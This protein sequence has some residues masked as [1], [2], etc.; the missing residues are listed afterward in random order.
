MTRRV[1]VVST[2]PVEERALRD[3]I[4]GDPA[5]IKVV[6][7]AAKLSRL[8]WLA[9]DD[10]E[11]IRKAAEAAERTASALPGKTDAEVGDSD[12][13]QAIEDALREWPADEVFVVTPPEEQATSLEEDA[14]KE[15]RA[16][17]GVPVTHLTLGHG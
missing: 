10:D 9:N 4:G 14:R 3:R 12:P 1:L 16:R 8:D 17:L 2:I 11:A 15:A 7:P 5:E 6:A 13:V